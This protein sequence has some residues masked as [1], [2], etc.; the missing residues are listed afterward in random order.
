MVI[1]TSQ[2]SNCASEKTKKGNL[3]DFVAWDR[4]AILRTTVILA[5]LHRSCLQR[6]FTFQVKHALSDSLTKSFSIRPDNSD[7]QLQSDESLDCHSAL[8]PSSSFIR[9]AVSPA[10][11]LCEQLEGFLSSTWQ[12]IKDQ[13]ARFTSSAKSDIYHPLNIQLL[14]FPT[15][16]AL[17]LNRKQMNIDAQWKNVKISYLKSCPNCAYLVQSNKQSGV[18]NANK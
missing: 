5:H 7:L 3:I 13:R 12:H 8:L 2:S 1:M 11:A 17:K 10:D 4:S 14:L 6:I 16:L 9:P 15:Q 18:N